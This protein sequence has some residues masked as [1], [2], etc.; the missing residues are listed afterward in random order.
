MTD[1]PL[2]VFDCEDTGFTGAGEVAEAE[3]AIFG[4]KLKNLNLRY[5]PLGL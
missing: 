2:A 5:R 4:L 1:L 3:I